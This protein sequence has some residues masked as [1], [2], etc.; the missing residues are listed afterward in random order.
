[1][2]TVEP[3]EIPACAPIRTRRLV[4]R[5]YHSGD[6]YSLLRYHGR[7][8]VCRYLLNEP[9]T[10]DDA[11]EVVHTRVSR[12]SIADGAVALVV[13]YK[14]RVVGNMAA[15]LVDG[16]DHTAEL[17]WVFSPDFAGQGFATEAVTALVELVFA[18]PRLHR[19]IAQ[20]DSR[21]ERSARLAERIKMRQEA[22]FRQNLWIKNEWT[23]TVV[24]AA[25]RSERT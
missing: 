21:N 16:T 14:G 23:D 11:R 20:M 15:W 9:W 1:M 2:Y 4:I 22:H 3:N 13:E 19:V 25:L 7:A 24:F 18:D 12:R 5:P 10:L 6:A 8:D 17:G